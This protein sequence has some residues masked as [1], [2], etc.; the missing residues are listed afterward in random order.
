MKP[1]I[2]NDSGED[3]PESFLTEWIPRVAK[4]LEARG[5]LPGSALQKELSLVFLREIDAKN[6]NWNY[7]QKDY[8]TDILTFQTEDPESFGE[9]VMCPL[10]L[11]K[12]ARANKHGDE[13]EMGYMILHGILH[14]LGFDHEKDE[15]SA[16]EMF[17][18]QDS[19]FQELTRPAKKAPAPKAA[20]A[21]AATKPKPS[22]S[23]T[24]PVSK[25]SPALKTTGKNGAA[26][27]ASP[28]ANAA[29]GKAVPPKK[30]TAAKPVKKAPPKKGSAPS[31]AGT[32]A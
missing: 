22:K 16:H 12:Q 28:K 25:P 2:I 21:T 15:K 5:V 6:L 4:T 19:V 8:A 27:T 10:V 11:K 18:L 17:R 23:A 32:R 13:H 29:K 1:L 14:L 31:R 26:K 3:V 30:T 24:K 7:R 9:L 20:K